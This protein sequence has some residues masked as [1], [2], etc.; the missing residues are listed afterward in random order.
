LII[1]EESQVD[2]DLW[3][4]LNGI[5][6][7]EDE[8]IYQIFRNM[9]LIYRPGPRSDEGMI[10]L[11]IPMGHNPFKYIFDLS[12]C[13]DKDQ[14]V[15]ITND[16][17]RFF[18]IGGENEDKLVVYFGP[19]FW[20]NKNIDSLS[21]PFNAIMTSWEAEQ[22]SIG[23][24]W[25]WSD[26]NNKGLFNYLTDRPVGELSVGNLYE[27]WKINGARWGGSGREGVFPCAWFSCLFVN[28]N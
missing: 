7:P 28:Q 27:H 12:S 6:T 26:W 21:E 8:V 22:A 10:R 4:V 14:Y 16:L 23:I 2:K 24:F 15:V 3:K 13:G 19:H 5:K 17:E 20:V 1:E 18:T 9:E 11:P 25:R